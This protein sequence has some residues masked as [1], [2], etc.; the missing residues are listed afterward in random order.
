MSANLGAN[1]PPGI[2]REDDPDGV[3]YERVCAA[4]W[5]AFLTWAADNDEIREA[6]TTTTGLV[7]C[8][9]SAERFV[10]WATVE[11]YGIEGAPAAYRAKHAAGKEK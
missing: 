4:A 11:V 10:E 1:L 9:T 3:L 6:F 2:L 5:P 7:I 8:A